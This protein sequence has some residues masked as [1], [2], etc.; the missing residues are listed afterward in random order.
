MRDHDGRVALDA[1]LAV[2]LLGELLER[3]HVVLGLGLGQVLLEAL[4][5]LRRRLRAVLV[6]HLL[7][8]EACVPDLEVRHR[9]EGGHRLPVATS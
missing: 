8:V 4:D 7:D 9:G 2:D 6:E 3:L 5:L 1:V